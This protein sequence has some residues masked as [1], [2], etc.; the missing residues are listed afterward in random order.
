MKRSQLIALG[1]IIL[2]FFTACKTTPP[3]EKNDKDDNSAVTST[4]RF[5]EMIRVEGG[6]FQIGSNNGDHDEKPIHAVTVRSFSMGK[7]P[8][9]QKEWFEIMGTTIQQQRD[10]VD[11][12]RSLYGEGD[13]YPMYYVNWLE[14][15]EYCNKRSI[16][17]GLAPAYSGSGNNITCNWNANGYR[18]PTEAEWEYAAKGGNRD[19]TVYEYSGS[20]SADSVAWYNGNSGRSTHP[21]GTKAPNSLGLYDMSGNVWEWCWDRYGRYSS[22]AQANPVGASSGSGRVGRGGGWDDS[23]RGVRSANRSYSTPYDRGSYLGFRL[24]H[25]A[26]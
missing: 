2:V 13:N 7:Y 8:V 10:M 11:G 22:G 6:T 25:N 3:T 19:Q 23:A 12:S 18:L 16:K 17:E 9:T 20:N 14:A 1:V 15:V 26:Q 21:V 4:E 24:A 5:V